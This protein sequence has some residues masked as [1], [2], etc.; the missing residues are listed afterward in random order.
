MNQL[1]KVPFLKI[2]IPY[3]I[4]IFYAIYNFVNI[5]YVIAIAVL[6]LF[7]QL[8]I[9]YRA[10]SKLKKMPYSTLGILFFA[11]FIFAG[12][13]RVYAFRDI[14]KANHFQ[15]KQ[16]RL[17]K[18]KVDDY[19]GNKGKNLRFTAKVLG[20][21][22]ADGKFENASGNILCYWDTSI[23]EKPK[24]GNQYW[25]NLKLSDIYESKNPK[26]FNYKQ[27][28][29]YYNIYFKTY[30]KQAGQISVITPSWNFYSTASNLRDW[31]QSQF[32]LYIQEKGANALASALI[33]GNKSDLDETT[34][35]NFSQ[36]GTLHVLAV[37]GLHVGI[38]FLIIGFITKPL[39]KSKAGKV[40]QMFIVLLVIWAFALLTG[41]SPS[42]QRAAIMFSLFSIGKITK[43]KSAGMNALFGSAFLMLS[44][45]PFLIV[46]VG[47]QLSYA[48]VLGIML[49]HKP[50]YE[51]LSFRQINNKFVLWII[52]RAW[53]ICSISFAAQLGTF[54][55][56]IFYFGSFPTYFMFSNLFVIPMIFVLVC[57]AIAILSFS[58]L[59]IVASFLAYFSKIL[60]NWVL[61]AVAYVSHLPFSNA[62]G[63]H[64]SYFDA[65]FVYLIIAVFI[66]FLHSKKKRQ[67]NISLALIVLFLVSINF[68]YV[69]N[70]NRTK[71]T[72][73]S[74]LRN[75]VFT[76]LEG[77][78]AYIIA[79]SQFC[80]HKSGQKFHLTPYFRS[81]YIKKIHLFA[82]E[83][84]CCGITKNDN[85]IT[86]IN[87]QSKYP[88][89]TKIPSN[90]TYILP[91][92]KFVQTWANKQSS[93]NIIWKSSSKFA[94]K[95]TD[96]FLELDSFAVDIHIK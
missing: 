40:L 73:H 72:A 16:A 28:L 55:I 78:E 14:N 70:A 2:L 33:L 81:E 35:L 24:L 75:Q 39:E 47:F 49:I 31:C 68:R 62:I 60:S 59:P 53:A 89:L 67:L 63:L 88:D 9:I 64:F 20:L 65:G 52:D 96:N 18:I 84:N 37:S 80:E 21:K 32:N 4:G 34:T 48:A 46:N 61:D 79:D 91:K 29:S 54:P 77:N 10:N 27:Y 26:E 19:P 82:I 11:L 5:Q 43:S 8:I 45:N 15:K 93:P 85:K 51:L 92:N 1:Q 6:V 74:T 83:G 30:I 42:V 22:T 17:F 23:L 38:I 7:C 13:A 57:L 71:L 25:L 50:I 12:L 69:K 87:H 90:I 41:F 95:T 58:W 94:L 3:I 76:Y 86:L 56:S 66:S 36:T 44:I